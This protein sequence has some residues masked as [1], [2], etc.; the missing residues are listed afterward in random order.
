M[1]QPHE[2]K[3][4]KHIKKGNKVVCKICNKEYSHSRDLKKH[5]VKNHNERELDEK[6]F[7]METFHEATMRA[8]TK[9]SYIGVISQKVYND[10]TKSFL[11]IDEETWK[12]V[13][14][15]EDIIPLL[16][17]LALTGAQ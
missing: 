7:P 5:Y 6:H 3:Y 9:N 1:H 10:E 8:N 17:L 13:E 16:K 14:K 15:L 12:A 11:Q 2:S 4:L